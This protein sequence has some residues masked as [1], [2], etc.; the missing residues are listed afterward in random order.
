MLSASSLGLLVLDPS[1]RG[2]LQLTGSGGV[3]DNTGSIVVDS[4]NAAAAIIT[5]SGGVT[6]AN[7]DVTGGTL[8]TGT[9]KFSTPVNHEPPTPDP[10]GLPLP[11]A[12]SQTFAAVNYSGSTPLTLSPGTYTGGIKITGTGSV[13]LESGVYYMKGGGFSL[14][15]QGSISG[16]GVLLVNAPSTPSDT[17]SLTGAGKMTLTPSDNLTGAYAAYDGIAILQDPAS[18]APIDIVGS[19]GLTIAGTIYAP[20]AALNIVGSGGMLINPDAATGRAEAI[21][22]DV[23]DTGS[24]SLV[25][26]SGS[27]QSSQPP[28]IAAP[29]N[30]TVN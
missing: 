4:N 23:S 2:A 24:G 16:S 10:V 8:V 26:N 29:A 12:P 14:T 3:T 18:T 21:V 25:L 6:A 28:T 27:G 5:G 20:K 1:G 11:P 22:F 7:I 15:G 17:I 30:V 13:T 9:G 19:G